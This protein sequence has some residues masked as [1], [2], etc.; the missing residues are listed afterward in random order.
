[1]SFRFGQ[2]WQKKNLCFRRIY[3]DGLSLPFQW[4]NYHNLFIQRM[5]TI[6]LS[7]LFSFF[8]FFWITAQKQTLNIY[9]LTHRN[10]ITL[11]PSIWLNRFVSLKFG[12]YWCWFLLREKHYSFPMESCSSLAISQ[13]LKHPLRSVVFFSFAFVRGK[14]CKRENQKCALALS[15]TSIQACAGANR[16]EASK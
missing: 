8:P 1:M 11:N 16:E 2:L 6:F 4:F 9:G 7:F 3:P 15:L 10:T 5:P 13:E 12:W 14:A